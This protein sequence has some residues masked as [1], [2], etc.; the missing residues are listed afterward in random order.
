M[1]R[2]QGKSKV[3]GKNLDTGFVAWGYVT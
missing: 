1:E 3:G 2:G